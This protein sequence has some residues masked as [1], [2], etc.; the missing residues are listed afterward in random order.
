MFLL[1][2]DGE[3][4]EDQYAKLW[5]DRGSEKADYV[6]TL[7]HYCFPQSGKGAAGMEGDNR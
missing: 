1:I 6:D 2:L 7:C 5:S 3:L 4:F